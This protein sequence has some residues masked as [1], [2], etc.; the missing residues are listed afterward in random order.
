MPA[1]S[2]IS[3][4]LNHAQSCCWAVRFGLFYAQTFHEPSVL[5]KRQSLSFRA[6]SRPLKTAAFKPLVQKDKPVT[7]PVQRLN[8]VA[9][10]PAEQKE[11]VCERIQLKLLLNKTGK[12][13]DTTSEICVSAGYVYVVCPVEII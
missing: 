10:T 4:H 6:T 13:I 9:A 1:F 2:M 12:A 3:W 5:L 11:R 7:L 8:P